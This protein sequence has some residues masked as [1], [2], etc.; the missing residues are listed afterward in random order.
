MKKALEELLSPLGPPVAIFG[1]GVSGRAVKELLERLG[2]NP[3]VYDEQGIEG[4]CQ[5]FNQKHA[6]C[7]SLVVYSPGFH[8]HHPW[9]RLARSSYCLCMSELDLASFYF[10]GEVIAVTGTNGKTTLTEFLAEAL[11]QLGREAHAVGNNGWPLSSLAGAP[12]T[13]SQLAVCEVSSFQA[14]TL[15]H[16]RCH[17]LLWTNFQEDHLDRHPTMDRYFAAKWNLVNRLG[18]GKALFVAGESVATAALRFGLSV[19][20][21]TSIVPEESEFPWPMPDGSAF[22]AG[23]QVPNLRLARQF[24]KLKGLPEDILQNCAECFP[25]RKHRLNKVCEIDGVSFWNDSKATNFA[26]AQAALE[27]FAG[28]V[29]WIG[30]GWN[31][32]GALQSFA[33]QMASKVKA[34]YLIG[35]TAQALAREFDLASATATIFNSLKDAVTEAVRTARRGDTILFSPGFSSFGMFNNFI[36]R[37]NCFDKTVLDLKKIHPGS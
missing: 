13:R 4:A 20:S 30:G 3:V 21:Y 14:E 34:A 31:G 10:Q 2:A 36:H 8:P 7:H 23:P 9:L 35:D 24:W 11:K 18:K 16:F 28:P 6:R 12:D 15:R 5:V 26:A 1:A 25:S 37:G 22:A 17:A 29:H 19:P 27:S 33:H 32:G